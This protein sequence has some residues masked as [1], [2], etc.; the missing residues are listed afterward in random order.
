MKHSIKNKKNIKNTK[1]THK[2]SSIKANVNSTKKLLSLDK[3]LDK[4]LDKSLV[5]I[6]DL[7]A[8]HNVVKDKLADMKKLKVDEEIPK[9][10]NLELYKEQKN[11]FIYIKNIVTNVIKNVKNMNT[12][13]VSKIIP[14]YIP[15]NYNDLNSCIK[16]EY[17]YKNKLTNAGSGAFGDVIQTNGKKYKYAIKVINLDKQD[18]Y[19]ENFKTT[20]EKIENEAD[21]TRKMS[22]LG[23]GPKLFDVYSCK[24]DGRLTYYF[25]LEYMNQGT[26]YEY[27]V[28]NNIKKIPNN[29]M[30]NLTNKLKKMHEHGY[31]HNDLHFNNILV[32]KCNGKIE[33]YISDFG[34]TKNIKEEKKYSLENELKEFKINLVSLTDGDKEN[35]IEFISKFILANY[36]IIL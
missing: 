2:S 27:V 36:K 35:E 28:K 15:L 12:N 9:L 8:L 14:E 25:V 13:M 24:V 10:E 4:L 21:I 7:S 5:N 31:L 32:N 17:N 20:V 19:L 29:M 26:L 6:I 22:K 18:D 11:N 3:P 1:N 34:S 30:V 23:I 16:A 33:F